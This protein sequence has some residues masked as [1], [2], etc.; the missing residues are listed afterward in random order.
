[1]QSP[2]NAL[3]DNNIEQYEIL[4]HNLSQLF[5]KYDLKNQREKLLDK[6][7]RLLLIGQMLLGGERAFTVK[8]PAHKLLKMRGNGNNLPDY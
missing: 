2:I 5:E 3:L 1:M 4:Y 8:L 7:E 6:I